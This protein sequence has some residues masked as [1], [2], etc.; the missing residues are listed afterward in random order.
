MPLASFTDGPILRFPRQAQFHPLRYLNGLARV[1][2]DAGGRICCHTRVRDIM[3]GA[4]A[5]VITVNGSTVTARA[6]VV[7]TN[8]PISDTF[9]IHTKQAPYRTYAMAFA[10]PKEHAPAG[11]FWDSGDPYHYVRCAI[12]AGSEA[13]LIVGGE[14]HKTGQT[15]DTEAHFEALERWTREHFPMAG[16]VQTRWSGQVME[17]VDHLAFIGRDVGNEN[18]Y[19]ATGDSGHGMTHGTIAGMLLTDL[20][21]QRPNPWVDLYSPQRRS[22]KTVATYAKENLNVA[23][24]FGDYLKPGEVAALTEIQRGSGA[25][26]RKGTRLVAV[27]RDEQD[28]F[29]A[30]SAICT[31]VGCIVHWNGTEKSWDCPCHGSR[32]DVNGVVLSG[33]ARQPLADASEMLNAD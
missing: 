17:P 15:A 4:P 5:Q 19:V 22:S 25:L 28:G 18:V 13:S 9:A 10:V 12:A 6:V 3:D 26:L 32:F 14:D 7:A 16:A 29:H 30:R 1:I 2:T 23:R 27:Y 11:L 31:H 8:S 21:L 33:P 20:I 24:Q